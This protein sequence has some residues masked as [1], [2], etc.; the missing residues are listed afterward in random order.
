MKFSEDERWRKP[1]QTMGIDRSQLGPQKNTAFLYI[2]KNITLRANFQTNPDM[3][4]RAMHGKNFNE[5][6]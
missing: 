4:D 5:T 1:L 3:Q 6:D 2:Y